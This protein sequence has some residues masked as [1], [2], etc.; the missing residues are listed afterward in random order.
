LTKATPPTLKKSPP[1]DA[2]YARAWK[3]MMLRSGQHRTTVGGHKDS[4]TRALASIASMTAPLILI[5]SE[6]SPVRFS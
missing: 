5:F 4:F 1:A 3:R 2:A 6:A